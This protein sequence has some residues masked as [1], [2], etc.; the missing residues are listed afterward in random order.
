MVIQNSVDV[1]DM[2]IWVPGLIGDG[3]PSCEFRHCPKEVCRCH[4][5]HLSRLSVIVGC[6]VI[7]G[8]RFGFRCAKN[9]LHAPPLFFGFEVSGSPFAEF[10]KLELL[11]SRFPHSRSVA[12]AR[13]VIGTQALLRVVL[14]PAIG[15]KLWKFEVIW[16]GRTNIASMVRQ[17]D[18]TVA[19]NS[20]TEGKCTF[21]NVSILTLKSVFERDE[22]LWTLGKY[23]GHSQSVQTYQMGLLEIRQALADPQMYYEKANAEPHASLH[24]PTPPHLAPLPPRAQPT[25]IHAQHEILPPFLS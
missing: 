10:R 7:H 15:T 1:L 13:L 19:L 24:L 4:R 23:G 17:M 2:F 22:I 11:L 20:G 9:I 6:G 8:S 14:V 5:R 18:D 25:K 21:K 16:I 12:F 3:G